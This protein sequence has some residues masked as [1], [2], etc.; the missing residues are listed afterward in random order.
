MASTVL[1]FETHFCGCT[2]MYSPKT[3]NVAT[4]HCTV[5][6]QTTDYF[7]LAPRNMVSPLLNFETHFC[8]YT[9]MYNPKTNNFATIHCTVLKQTTDYFYLAPRNMASTLLNFE[10]HTHF[11]DYTLCTILKRTI[12]RLNNVQS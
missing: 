6:K 7:Y 1:N 4:I 8:G 12:S 2:F 10:T 9:F 11:C 3:N 5:L